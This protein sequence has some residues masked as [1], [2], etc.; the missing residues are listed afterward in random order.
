M[1]PTCWRA[2]LAAFTLAVATGSL[3]SGQSRTAPG[4]R[5]VTP[6]AEAPASLASDPFFDDTVLHE[7]RLT[8]NSRDWQSLKDHFLDNTYY[9]SDFKWRDTTVR[10]VGIRSRGTGSRSGIKP[11][12]RVD[13]D[14]YSTSQKFLGL[15]S[16]VLRNNTQDSSNM[17]E[18]LSMLLFK[19]MR[20]AA[21][22]V[23]HTKLYVNNQ[24]VGLYTIVE[25]IDKT[26][27]ENTYHEDGGYLFKYDYPLD[28]P[29]YYFESRGT[30]PAAYVPLP[31][32]PETHESDP[33]AEAIERLVWTINETNDGVFRSAIAEFLDVELFLR[34]VAVVVFLGDGDGFLG[35]WGMNN[36][37]LYRFENS[38]LFEMIAWDKSNAFLDG[39]TYPIW[40]NIDD[41]EPERQNRLMA[42]LLSYPDLKQRYLDFLS[43]VVR[44]AGELEEGRTEGAGWLERE[45]QR[46]Y[47]QIREAAHADAEKPYSN[48]E[49]ESAVNDLGFFARHRAEIVNRQIGE[50]RPR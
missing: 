35:N 3:V 18:R 38:N 1:R 43:D 28:A 50:A 45:I 39:W 17:H 23:A 27:L 19:R 31:F 30:D 26:F 7:I 8:I 15:K 10:N 34:H 13:F 21:P 2:V 4:T 5:R 42:R 25:S 24:Y 47:E 29:P 37:Y 20:V 33:Q 48:D 49:F 36:F 41:V 14:R 46:E 32:Q 40:H 22:R 16:F 6:R 9:P 44:S 11:G 12:L